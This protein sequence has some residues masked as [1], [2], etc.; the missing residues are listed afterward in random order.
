MSFFNL[1]YFST[2]SWKANEDTKKNVLNLHQHCFTDKQWCSLLKKNIYSVKKFHIW[3]FHSKIAKNNQAWRH[4][5]ALRNFHEFSSIFDI[6]YHKEKSHEIIHYYSP[7]FIFCFCAEWNLAIHT[8]DE[9]K[10]ILEYFAKPNK[11]KKYLYKLVPLSQV[12]W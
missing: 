1:T 9:R 6:T 3:N 4:F 12:P 10:Y 8:F 7:K 5:I 2:F 11:S